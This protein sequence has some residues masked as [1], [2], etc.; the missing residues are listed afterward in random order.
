VDGYPVHQAQRHISA[1][2]HNN[3]IDC[4]R[5][6]VSPCYIALIPSAARRSH[7]H[8]LDPSHKNNRFYQSGRLRL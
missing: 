1:V 6:Y 5:E 3:Q 7:I 2:D 4:R 8:R